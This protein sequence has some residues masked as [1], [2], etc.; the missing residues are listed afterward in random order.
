MAFSCAVCSNRTFPTHRSFRSHVR[1][2]KHPKASPQK[3]RL[4]YHPRIN[5]RPCNRSGIFL[6]N[7]SPPP[8]REPLDGFAPFEDRPS[9][10]FAEL[11]YEKMLC[12]RDD[13]NQL[14]RIWAAKNVI[15]NT[16]TDPVFAAHKDML[17]TIDSIPW[18]DAP[19]YSFKL[20]WNGP[21]TPDSPA[22]KR[23]EY[24]VHAQNPLQ[25]FENMLDTSEYK[26]KFHP[27]A[28]QE[29]VTPG[30]RRYSEFMSGHWPWKESSKIA[31]DPSTHGSML[32]TII[33]GADKTT[34]SV[35]T[36][37]QE[38][39]P[40]Y[41]SLGVFH[42]DVRRGHQNAVL[43]VAF[44]AIPK[45][46]HEDENDPDFRVFKKQIY[47]AALARV[48]DPVKPYMTEP[49]ITRC[50]DGHY[51][52]V[53]YS[54]GPFIA[55]YPEQVYLSGVVQG[56]CPKCFASTDS[57]EPGEPRFR[58]LTQCIKD[59]YAHDPEV[60]WDAFGIA[61]GVKPFTDHFPRADIHEA[62]SPDLLHQ[63]IKGTFK[64]HLVEWVLEYIKTHHS[65]HEA[66]ALIDDLDRRLRSVPAFPGLRRFK[67]GRNFKQWTGDDS[68]ALMKIFIPAITGIVPD[69]VVQCVRTFLD[70]CYIARRSSHDSRSLQEMEDTL[71]RFHEL[72]SVFRDEDV[73]NSFAL[74]RQHAL[75]HFVRGIRLFGSPNGLCTSITES[76]HIRAVKRPWR[77]TNKNNPLIQILE[78]NSRLNKLAAAR[79]EFGSH[80]MLQDDVLTAARRDAQP[81]L[82][83]DENAHNIDDGGNVDEGYNGQ[84][85]A[86]DAMENQHFADVDGV[87]GDPEPVS[88]VLAKRPAC[89]RS[90][91]RLD[92]PP[93]I[94]A[95]LPE[96]I[97]RLLHDQLTPDASDDSDPDD[98]DIDDC[99]QFYGNV[100]IYHSARAFFYAPSELCGLGGMHSEMI[101]SHP[102][103]YSEYER[104]DTVLIQDGPEDGVMGGM[105]VGR[106]LAF[107]SF[108]HNEI[109]YPC[110]LVEWFFPVGD[111]PDSVTGMWVVK[112]RLIRGERDVGLVHTDCIVRACHLAPLYGRAP[113]PT[114]FDFSYSHVAFGSFYYNKYVD[115]HA[116][117]CY[118][119]A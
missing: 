12:S 68:K 31:S 32:A 61:P 92:L 38:F 17:K 29:F 2:H 95:L 55:D 90:V 106:V 27:A 69:R 81:E 118:P 91:A 104:R 100:A 1:E 36:G 15:D 13:V 94:K 53:I 54:L 4:Y 103:W 74:P 71:R 77:A 41:A 107:L 64:D 111:E 40:V 105:L 86:A 42:N 26:H 16:G 43:P 48:F 21:I 50:P 66:N 14:L 96:L 89:S 88:I 101:R 47:H 51:R 85:L 76:K 72:R 44:L 33:A 62:L 63:V 11:V 58:D 98:V 49:R 75:A 45:G 7:G 39:H 37:N 84:D 9:F 117:E 109:T 22:W 35:A 65:T 115:Y 5:G 30:G 59:T 6:P 113:L 24:V 18:G 79:S 78:V 83:F 116:H 67:E 102:H 110:A 28:Y 73:R 57:L 82:L 93:R 52:K 97:R 87:D 56:H 70:F 34:V 3:S 112:P 60:L 20:R 25:I 114:D 19:W 23:A 80:G 8:P 46:S 119:L 108:T 99:P 10:E